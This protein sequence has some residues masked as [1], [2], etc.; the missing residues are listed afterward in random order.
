MVD[1][2]KLWSY[3]GLKRLKTHQDL[4]VYVGTNY[5]VGSDRI[6]RTVCGSKIV[7]NKTN[8]ST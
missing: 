2:D 7:V 5:F 4:P 3:S 8:T 1:L 6:I